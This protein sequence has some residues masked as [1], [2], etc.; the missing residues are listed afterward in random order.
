MNEDVDTMYVMQV[1]G[2][3]SRKNSHPEIT[4]ARRAQERCKIKHV[5]RI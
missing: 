1:S 5:E 4:T 3:P 2:S